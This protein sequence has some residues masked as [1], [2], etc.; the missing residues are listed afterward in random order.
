MTAFGNS[1]KPLHSGKP[2]MSWILGSPI[3]NRLY[4]SVRPAL[5]MVIA[6]LWVTMER[7]AAGS[8]HMHQACGPAVVGPTLAPLYADDI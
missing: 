3:Q 4:M 1:L 8:V 6:M 2:N 5:Q 7:E